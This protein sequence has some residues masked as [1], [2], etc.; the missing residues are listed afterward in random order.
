LKGKKMVMPENPLSDEVPALLKSH[1]EHL[2]GSAISIDVIRE[3]GYES[4]LGPTPLKEAGFAPSQTKHSP[5][6]LIPNY[7]PDGTKT[8]HVYRPDS[9]RLNQKGKSIKYEQPKGSSLRIDCPPRCTAMIGDPGIPLYITEGTKKTD[10][11]ASRGACAIGLNGVWGWKGRNEH[12]GTTILTDWDFIA[13]K[14]REVFLVFDSDSATNPNVKQALDRLSE[15]LRRKEALVKV[16]NLLHGEDGKKLGVDDWFAAGHILDEL[17]EL[18]ADP[19][20][21]NDP[22]IA[23]HIPIYVIHDGMHCLI[24]TIQG[25]GKVYSPLCN[26]VGEITEE[27]IKDDGIAESRAFAIDGQLSS[28]RPLPQIEVSAAEFPGMSWVSGMWGAH[29]IVY[30]GSSTK[31]HLRCFLQLSMNGSNPRRVFTHTGWRVVDG[32]RV[33]LT[34]SG[35]VGAEG[36]EVEMR[37]RLG[38]YRLPTDLDEVDP[39]E[40][41]KASLRF[42]DDGFG[43]HEVMATLWA[44]MYLSP[45]TEILDPAFTLWLHG[46]SGS[47]K[48][49]LSALALCHFGK[50]TYLTLPTSWEYTANRLGREMFILKDLPLVI[51]DWAPGATVAAQ[52]EMEAKVAVVIRAQ[53]NRIGRGRLNADSS[54]KESYTPRGLVITSGEQ[55]PGGESNTARLFVLDLEPGDVDKGALDVAQEE[56]HLYRYA[57]ANYIAWLGTRWDE[58]SKSLRTRWRE[59]RD[60]AISEGIHLRLPGTVAWLY[61]GLEMGMNYAAE[62]GAVTRKDADSNLARGW[63]AL[64]ELAHHQGDRVNEER[65]ANRFI[66]AFRALLTQEKLIVIDKEYRGPSEVID[67]ATAKP[68]TMRPG[69]VFV[70]WEDH[71]YYYLVPKLVFEVVAEFYSRSGSPLTFKPN[72]VWADLL[73]LKMTEA[74]PGRVDKVVRVGRDDHSELKTVIQLLKSVVIEKE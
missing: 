61:L 9:P 28:G 16:V 36:Y 11:L 47:F 65:P 44:S 68:M 38:Q 66:E 27:I 15:Y 31:D 18:V 57:M 32:E 43:T 20:D 5:G 48:S 58:I 51:D 1:L 14:H 45:L 3:R 55:L 56:A 19:G 21:E 35:A 26:F 12:G 50:F 59:K 63:K 71:A 49:V 62:I 13:I 40:A 53:G 30:S 25:I 46:H 33:F 67:F 22:A 41:M 39:V 74:R 7:A 34:A 2:R 72:A 4:I 73:R 70:G 29:A 6:I 8:G 64:L 60:E 10:S 42:M 69:Q 23:L 17:A 37:D 52:R 24:R 54:P